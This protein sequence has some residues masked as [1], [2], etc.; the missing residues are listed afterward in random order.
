MFINVVKYFLLYGKIQTSDNTIHVYLPFFSA[1][2]IMVYMPQFS[3]TKLIPWVLKFKGRIW[4]LKIP[5][6]CVQSSYNYQ[7][8][9]AEMPNFLLY[10]G[11]GNPKRHYRSVVSK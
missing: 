6:Y 3:Y 10:P 11:I 7:M 9:V 1:K 4:N 5:T 8:F 2:N